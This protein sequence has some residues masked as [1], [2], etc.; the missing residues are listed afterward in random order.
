A[1]AA[2]DRRGDATDVRD[3]ILEL[4]LRRERRVLVDADAEVMKARPDR[5]VRRPDRR[6]RQPTDLDDRP[7]GAPGGGAGGREPAWPARSAEPRPAPHQRRQRE[8]ARRDEQGGE[9]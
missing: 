6:R 2:R 5:D 1:A 7:R 9:R 4:L 3:G 8:L